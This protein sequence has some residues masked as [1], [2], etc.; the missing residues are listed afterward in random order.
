MER[1]LRQP[2]LQA[3]ALGYVPERDQAPRARNISGV[4]RR[5]RDIVVA[6]RRTGA[7]RR[8]FVRLLRAVVTLEQGNNLA[9]HHP[10]NG[11]PDGFRERATQ[12]ALRSRVE[13]YDLVLRVQDD[14][15][16][17]HVVDDNV[18]CYRHE[19]QWPISK[20]WPRE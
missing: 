14:H 4:Q 6:W 15:S 1:L 7:Q 16:V 2:L 12:D 17:H 10:R 9:G 18:A 20:K 11:V 5:D 8:L 3:L 13:V 19:I